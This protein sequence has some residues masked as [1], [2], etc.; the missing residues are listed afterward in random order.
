MR[1][2]RRIVI[3][4]ML[5]LLDVGTKKMHREL[6]HDAKLILITQQTIAFNFV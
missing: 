2:M 1:A 6:D 3:F 4:L 5:M